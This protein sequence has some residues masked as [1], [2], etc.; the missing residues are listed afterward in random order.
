MCER[1]RGDLEPALEGP[2]VQRLDVPQHVLELEAAR[3]DAPFREGPEH[4]GVIRV[5]AV[6]EVD[7]H[8]AGR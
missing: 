8:G 7:E 4:E 2:L 5:G 1:D 3:V 6:A